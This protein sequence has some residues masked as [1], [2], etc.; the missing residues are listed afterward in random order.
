MSDTVFTSP[1]DALQDQFKSN[2][3]TFPYL[4]KGAGKRASNQR[5][6]IPRHP[7]LKQNEGKLASDFHGETE[8]AKKR[9]EDV[10]RTQLAREREMMKQNMAHD[11]RMKG[12][13]NKDPEY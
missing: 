7:F 12:T 13:G 4:K 10:I 8:F 1:D 3:T 2:K 5:A 6:D 9:K 11:L